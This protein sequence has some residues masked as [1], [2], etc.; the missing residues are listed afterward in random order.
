MSNHLEF[1]AQWLERDAFFLASALKSYA[2]SEGLDDD[3]LAAALKCNRE[4][5]T[6]LRLCRAPEQDRFQADIDALAAEF[7]ADAEALAVA[8]RRGQAIASLQSRQP[9]QT[10]GMLLAARD[11]D[12][13]EPESGEPS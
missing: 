10:G 8:V 13:P 1:M 9:E 6:M 4:T 7:H 12:R 5:L 3:A 2:H 11:D